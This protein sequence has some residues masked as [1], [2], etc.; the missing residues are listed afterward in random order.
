[1]NDLD[2][3]RSIRTLARLRQLTEL[4]SPS[5]HVELLNLMR[6]ALALRWRELGLD[7]TTTPGS[8]GDHLV[9]EWCVPDSVGHVLLVTHYDT[10]WSEGELARQPFVVDGDRVFGPGVFDMKA[11][12][13]AIE[14]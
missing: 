14:R 2:G 4:E 7:V 12:I 6:D 11:G 1:M 10:V 8:S 13:V 5:G 9:A 3:D